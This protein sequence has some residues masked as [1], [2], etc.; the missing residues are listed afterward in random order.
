MTSCFNI[1]L[2][3][4]IK[5]TVENQIISPLDFKNKTV[6]SDIFYLDYTKFR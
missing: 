3:R 1:T 5:N 6:E 2:S 4:N